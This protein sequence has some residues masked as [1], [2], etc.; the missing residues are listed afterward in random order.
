M[1]MIN[2]NVAL[3]GLDQQFLTQSARHTAPVAEPAGTTSGGE[4]PP[5]PADS[6][7]AEMAQQ[8]VSSDE[9]VMMFAALRA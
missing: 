8:P 9:S 4:A 7:S 3:S 5:P 6:T 2:L 1:S